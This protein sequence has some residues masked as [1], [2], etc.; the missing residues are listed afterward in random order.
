MAVEKK[1]KL[2]EAALKAAAFNETFD[3]DAFEYCAERD[4]ATIRLPLAVTVEQ[5]AQFREAVEADDLMA[6]LDLVD[7]WGYADSSEQLRKWPQLAVLSVIKGW[8]ATIEK[9][10]GIALG[11]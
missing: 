4:G 2:A 3:F 1:D 8:L 10:Q 5:G 6:Y 7:D 9:T 11:E